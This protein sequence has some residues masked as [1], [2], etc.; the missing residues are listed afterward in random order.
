[1]DPTLLAASGENLC[2]VCNSLELQVSQLYCEALNVFVNMLHIT[3]LNSSCGNF[4]WL[5]P[6]MHASFKNS[7]LKSWL[8]WMA[9][10]ISIQFYRDCFKLQIHSHGVYTHGLAA[11]RVPPLLA[12]VRTDGWRHLGSRTTHSHI[13]VQCAGHLGGMTQLLLSP[14]GCICPAR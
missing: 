9:G 13:L 11:G 1:M 10:M 4:P 8:G 2:R 14:L 3:N 7:M 12:A 6:I 5:W